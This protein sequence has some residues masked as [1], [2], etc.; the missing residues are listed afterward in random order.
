MLTVGK[1][2]S[3][4]TIKQNILFHAL[5]NSEKI[6]NS[7][8]KIRFLKFQI[9]IFSLWAWIFL[10]GKLIQRSCKRKVDFFTLRWWEKFC[11]TLTRKLSRRKKKRKKNQMKTFFGLSINSMLVVV[12]EKPLKMFRCSLI[13]IKNSLKRGEKLYKKNSQSY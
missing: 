12:E 5:T 2:S 10:V 8:S 1:M 4:K 11:S 9:Y 7:E 6:E 13:G 3:F